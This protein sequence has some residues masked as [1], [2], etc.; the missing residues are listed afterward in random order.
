M[1]NYIQA[2]TRILGGIRLDWDNI[3]QSRVLR[4]REMA[5]TLV[6]LA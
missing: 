1:S 5:L 6:L 4:Q 3:W 2:G